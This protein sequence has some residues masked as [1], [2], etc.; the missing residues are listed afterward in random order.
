MEDLEMHVKV[1]TR[2]AL[3]NCAEGNSYWQY[4]RQAAGWALGYQQLTG[5]IPLCALGSRRFAMEV[6]F[7]AARIMEQLDGHCFNMKLPGIGVPSD[8]H[9]TQ[10]GVGIG[11]GQFT[12]NETLLMIC[13]G[14]VSAHT[15]KL[16]APM[17][18]APVMY[19]GS[20][21]G[22]V[23]KDLVLAACRD[24]PVAL[25]LHAMAKRLACTGGDGQ[26]VRGGPDARHPSSA[27]AELI[28]GEVH[29]NPDLTCTGTCLFEGSRVSFDIRPK[30]PPMPCR[31]GS[32]MQKKYLRYSRATLAPP[33][34]HRAKA[35]PSKTIQK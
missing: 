1:L 5:R 6:E 21:S 16:H 10:D 13:L 22:S 23:L 15:G 24:H 8:L 18:S 3:S 35:S 30:P 12:R 26:M 7:L 32:C 4:E 34:L 17:L 11:F 31:G 14:C 29:G 20:H 33:P 25:G 9:L 19:L 2:L 28:W 27:A